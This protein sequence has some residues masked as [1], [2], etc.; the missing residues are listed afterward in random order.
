MV[1]VAQA[2]EL[3]YSG[4]LL[5]GKE[6]AAIGLVLRS[7]PAA[8]L[9]QTV[10]ELA[11]SFADKSRAALGTAKR[12]LNK[13]LG[14]DTPTGVEQERRELIRYVREPGSAALAGLRA[15]LENAPPR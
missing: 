5:S 6:S 10:T 14:V 3:I 12:Q 9:E 1:G 13:G 4:R 8:K 11:A 7:V 2:R 15:R